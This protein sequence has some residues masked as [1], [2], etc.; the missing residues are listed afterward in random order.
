MY[1][2]KNRKKKNLKL[3][4]QKKRDELLKLAGNGDLDKSIAY[5]KKVSKKVIN[6]KHAKYQR[7]SMED[8]YDFL[9]DLS[10]S[11]FAKTL[12]GFDVVESPDVLFKELQK[13]YC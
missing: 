2:L 1:H 4:K 9:T 13:M 10:I 5:I 8:A 3:M 6:K 12:G 11:L 7:K